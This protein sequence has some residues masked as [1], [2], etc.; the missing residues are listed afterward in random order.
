MRW[1]SPR[2]KLGNKRTVRAFAWFPTRI[3]GDEVIWFEPYTIVQVYRI[4]QDGMD[5]YARWEELGRVAQP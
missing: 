3:S 2:P 4:V 5:C 1:T